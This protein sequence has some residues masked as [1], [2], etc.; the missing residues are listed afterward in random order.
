MDADNSCLFNSVGYVLENHSRNKAKELRDVISRTVES[1]PELYN[2]AFLGKPT[3][4][5]A[6]WIM[7]DESWGGAIELSILSEY[8]RTEI[9]AFDTKTLRMVSN[10]KLYWRCYWRLY[11]NIVADDL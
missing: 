4:E 5:Y 7:K 1:N 6:K 10:R 3:K 11:C 9:A 2:E 8:Y